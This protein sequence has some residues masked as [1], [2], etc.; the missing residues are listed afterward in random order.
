MFTEDLDDAFRDPETKREE[1]KFKIHPHS[2]SALKTF[3]IVRLYCNGQ[4][5]FISQSKQAIYGK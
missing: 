2:E 3:F 5:I 4:L 1:R